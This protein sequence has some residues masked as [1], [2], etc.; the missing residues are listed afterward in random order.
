MNEEEKLTLLKTL[1]EQAKSLEDT[2]MQE[3]DGV[4]SVVQFS[5]GTKG[6][7]KYMPRKRVLGFDLD[8]T[9]FS[10]KKAIEVTNRKL[11]IDIDIHF[12]TQTDFDLIYYATMDE[13]SQ[14]E[15]IKGSRPNVKMTEYLSNEHLAGSEI[16]LITARNVKYAQATIKEL[17]DSGIYFDKIYFT[18]RKLD[19]VFSEEIDMFFDDKAETIAEIVNA[20][21]R[22]Y[23]V[24]VSA[25]YN[26]DS[27]VYDFR[28]KVGVD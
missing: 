12:M 7:V 28:F 10:I 3:I 21:I 5:R 9:I 11:G 18:S 23:G 6:H 2:G 16:I 14:N 25:P 1:K 20:D 27:S 19:L 8:G 22:T 4:R 24:L 13:E 26:R 15:I 17:T